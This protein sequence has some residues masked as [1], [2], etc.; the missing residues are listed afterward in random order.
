MNERGWCPL[1]KG[2]PFIK[3][4]ASTEELLFTA[5]CIRNVISERA[6]TNPLMEMLDEKPN[7]FR[8]MCYVASALLYELFD[9]KG[10]T[11]YKKK[12]YKDD[13]HWWI[14]TDD[15]ETIDITAEQYSIDGKEVPSMSYEGAVVAE[16]MWYPSYKKRI[17]VLKEELKEYL[18]NIDEKTI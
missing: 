12:D 4:E 15:G 10:V 2:A 16:L 6:E 11:L 8:N 14:R 7:P 13:Y 9:G 5:K 1:L 3:M 18:H 17:A